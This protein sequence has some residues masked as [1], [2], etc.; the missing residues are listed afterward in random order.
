M[1]SH[2]A[3]VYKEYVRGHYIMRY[4]TEKKAKK[5]AQMLERPIRECHAMEPDSM[6]GK[7]AAA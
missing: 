2:I 5:A 4:M 7:G 1:H 6:K 3:C